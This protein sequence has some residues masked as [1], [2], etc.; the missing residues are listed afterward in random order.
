MA[1]S[2]PNVKPCLAL[3]NGAVSSEDLDNGWCPFGVSFPLNQPEKGYR[4]SNTERP[5]LK[6][7][8]SFP[9]VCL[10]GSSASETVSDFGFQDVARSYGRRTALCAKAAEN[11]AGWETF[12]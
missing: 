8:G 11:A 2:G 5:I 1:N 9:A 7:H 12:D 4:A 6:I 3:R 10:F